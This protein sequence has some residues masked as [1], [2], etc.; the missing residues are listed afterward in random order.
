M[1][2]IHESLYQTNDFSQIKFSEYVISLSQN[3]V[4]TYEVFDNFVN[5]KLQVK[6]VS[7]NLDQSIPCGLLI[8]ELISNALKYAFPKN[9]KGIITVGLFEKGNTIFLN[10]KDNGDGLPNNIDYRDTDSLGLQLVM[11]LTEQLG[12]N[13][14]L[15]NTKGANYSVTFKKD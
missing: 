15:D 4:H 2:F 3:L 11:T 12:G 8:N 1:A 5:L 6:E 14:E 10:I 13:I 9:K 7:L